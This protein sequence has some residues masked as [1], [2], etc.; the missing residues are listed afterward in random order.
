MKKIF[1]IAFAFM[2]IFSMPAFAGTQSFSVSKST[3]FKLFT[4]GEFSGPDSWTVPGSSTTYTNKVT[5]TPKAGQGYTELSGTFDTTGVKYGTFGSSGGIDDYTKFMLHSDGVNNS[6]KF[7]D[8]AGKSVVSNGDA[9]IST[10]QNKFGGA[11]ARFNGSSS[12]LVTSVDKDFD[13]DNADLTYDFWMWLD[14]D[15]Y[16]GALSDRFILDVFKDPN[17]RVVIE[18]GAGHFSLSLKSSNGQVITVPSSY[19]P[20][21]AWVHTAIVKQGDN[22]KWYVNGVERANETSSFH[23][24]VSGTSYLGTIGKYYLTDAYYF[25]GYIDEFR[26][27]KGIARWTSD[28]TPPSVPYSEPIK[29]NIIVTDSEPAPS[30]STTIVT[31][32]AVPSYTVPKDASFR[33]T[34]P[35]E[36]SGPDS[37]TAAG[38]PITYTNK[39]TVTP[40]T[41]LGYTELTGT[42]SSVGMKYGSFGADTE[43]GIDTNTKLMLHMDGENGSTGFVDETGK[44]ATNN[45]NVQISTTQS[46]FGGASCSFDGSGDYLT[47]ADSEDWNFGNG[48]FTVDFW[49]KRTRTNTAE[50]LVSQDTENA[51]SNFAW[52]IYIYSNDR[53]D[54]STA[55]GNSYYSITNGTI[56]IT[57]TNWHH[58]AMVRSGTN[59]YGFIDGVLSGSINTLGSLALNNSTNPLIIGETW[60][61]A[62]KHPF[63]GNIDEVR[64]SKGIARW[65]AN[66][67][68]PTR[69]YST[70]PQKVNICVTDALPIT[71]PAV[72]KFIK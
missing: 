37:W 8:E 33:I 30:T 18:Y 6:T 7:I 54:F 41:G 58:Y 27:S 23:A 57:D 46:K 28:F 64:I 43:G 26:L 3:L 49:A 59:L 19:Y 63:S 22:W 20:T 34:V 36:F 66:F 52:S 51:I 45:G 67:T 48:D 24:L 69:A 40:K 71:A 16:S 68:T 4:E 14:S 38:S 2:F 11:S 50:M 15:F 56:S 55:V 42:F 9:K 70:G 61:Y 29:A 12:Y 72:V 62:T 13:V 60:W 25:K 17:N 39:V 21:Q 65:T 10:A 1:F 31:A 53:V 44:T 32:A 5:A 47:F 35:G